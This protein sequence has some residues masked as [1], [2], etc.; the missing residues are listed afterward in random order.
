MTN[1]HGIIGLPLTSWECMEY[2]KQVQLFQIAYN[3]YERCSKLEP[4]P[5]TGS[6]LPKK[7]SFQL[8]A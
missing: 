1:V 6:T 2:T 4:V 3:A 5:E 7:T 8:K